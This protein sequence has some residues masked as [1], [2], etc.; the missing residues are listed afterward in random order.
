MGNWMRTGISS[1]LVGS[2]L[3]LLLTFNMGEG[4]G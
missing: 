3:I 2:T 4:D 1:L